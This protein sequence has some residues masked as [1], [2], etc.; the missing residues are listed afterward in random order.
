MDMLANHRYIKGAK[1]QGNVWTTFGHVKG[2]ELENTAQAEAK[3]WR[4]YANGFGRM[5][6]QVGKEIGTMW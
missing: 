6:D 4:H 3:I 1:I 5:W 2:R